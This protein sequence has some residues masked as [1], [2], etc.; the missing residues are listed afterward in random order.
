METEGKDLF[1]EREEMLQE[2]EEMVW[3]GFLLR[4]NTV[5]L[6]EQTPVHDHPSSSIASI[7][8]SIFF[9]PSMTFAVASPLP[10]LGQDE[11]ETVLRRNGSLGRLPLLG[12]RLRGLDPVCDPLQLEQTLQESFRGEETEHGIIPLQ[13]A[14]HLTQEEE[15][16]PE[17]RMPDFT[18]TSVQFQFLED[19]IR[20]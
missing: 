20:G 9:I 7:I 8:A 5:G 4:N 1:P 15:R 18:P 2:E 12:F 10:Q 6:L 17:H 14:V 3:K 16:G 13:T 19:S 11:G